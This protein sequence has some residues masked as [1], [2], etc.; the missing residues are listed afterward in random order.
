MERRQLDLVLITVSRLATA[1]RVETR[2]VTLVR[3]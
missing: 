3:T 1:R 2:L